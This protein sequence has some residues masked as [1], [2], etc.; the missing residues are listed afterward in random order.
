[1]NEIYMDEIC[2]KEFLGEVSFFDI[3]ASGVIYSR[4][5]NKPKSLPMGTEGVA[6]GNQG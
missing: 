4:R 3:S 2:V 5:E 1:M 6:K